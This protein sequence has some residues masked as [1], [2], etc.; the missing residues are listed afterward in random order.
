MLT[1]KHVQPLRSEVASWSEKLKTISEVLELWL[2][3]QD[4]WICVESVFTN[5][6]TIK[7]MSSV[8]KKPTLAQDSLKI[9]SLLIDISI[10]QSGATTILICQN[11]HTI[12]GPVDGYC[13]IIP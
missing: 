1:S 11:R 12:L 10:R 8:M 13:R 6:T 3:V 7:E 5:P 9:C 2:E 4:L